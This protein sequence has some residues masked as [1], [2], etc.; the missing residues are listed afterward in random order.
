MQNMI[1]NTLLTA[2]PDFLVVRTAWLYGPGKNFVGAILR[3]AQLRR[4]GEVAG[5]LTVVDD[6]SLSYEV[7]TPIIVS[8]PPAPAVPAISGWARVALPILLAAAGLIFGVL[9]S[10]H[11]SA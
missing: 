6:Q 3:Q 2:S 10:E 9:R 5:P 1:D 11:R 4:K 8:A 7:E